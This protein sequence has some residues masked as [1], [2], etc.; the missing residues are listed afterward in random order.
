[1]KKGR[2]ITGGK[3]IKFRKKKLRENQG[4]KRKVKLGEE[5]RKVK[6]VTGGNIKVMMYSGKYVNIQDKGKSKKLE[7]KNVIETPS[8]K[9]LAR[10]NLIT[11]GTI[12]LTELG[13]VKIT[14]RPSQNGIINGI[15]VK[16]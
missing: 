2:K 16:E 7:I 14:S 8:D 1:M 5:K 15:L 9:F 10:Q 3:Y 11:K 12:V 6:K 13:K 4:Q